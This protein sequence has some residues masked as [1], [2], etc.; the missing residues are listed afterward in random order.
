VT[1]QQGP[2]V[3]EVG[4]LELLRRLQPYLDHEAQGLELG[5]GDDAALWHPGGDSDIVVTTD[6]LVQGVHFHPQPGDAL[7]YGSLGWKLLAISLS[8]LAA[9]G[10]EP[11]PALLALALPG[12]WPVADV[13][14]LYHGLAECALEHGA[15]L[16]GGNLSSAATAVLTSTCLG[17]VAA[18]RALRR[19]GAEPGWKLAC[20]GG[21]GGA[22]AALRLFQDPGAEEARLVPEA[23]RAAWVHRLRRPEPRLT[24]ARAL[25]EEGIRVCLDVSDGLYL[26][27]ARL[28]RDGLGAVIEPE[29]LPIEPGLREAFPGAW[30]Q[31]AG[32]GEDYELL[33]AGPP[34][35]VETACRRLV[36]GGLEATVIGAF[37]DGAGLRLREADGGEALAP[38]TGHVHFAG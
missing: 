12:D 37:D 10:A 17:H 38:A 32:G 35:K 7:F 26:D 3:R 31:I 34:D 14:A 36:A 25:V 9:M 19:E 5:A 22:A 33:F 11:G 30:I 20:T 23:T 21:L 27:A 29:L 6:S 1:G 15:V 24:S 4:E 13:E 16:A 2:L 28:L 18:G 8:D